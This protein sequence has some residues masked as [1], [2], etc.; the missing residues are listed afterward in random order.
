[1]KSYHININ[2]NLGPDITVLP[3]KRHD[4]PKPNSRQVFARVRATLSI[5]ASS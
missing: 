2:I 1:M 3:V 4:Q 5:F